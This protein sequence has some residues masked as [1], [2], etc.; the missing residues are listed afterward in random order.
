MTPEE[1]FLMTGSFSA[2]GSIP[3]SVV[4]CPHC[5]G[6]PPKH[7]TRCPLFQAT[8]IIPEATPEIPEV[9][10]RRLVI[11]PASDIR[12]RRVSWLW[13][14][15][16]KGAPPTSHGR[17]PMNALTIAAGHGGTG[18]TQ[19]ACWMTAQITRG[20]L[21]GELYGRP[22]SV[23][24]ASTE[25]SWSQT[26]APRLIAAGADMDRVFRIEVQDDGAM[27]ARLTLPI[28]TSLLGQAAEEHDA[29]LF[30]ADPLLSLLDDGINDYRAREVRSALEPLI[31][32][33]ERHRF[34][35]LG[36]AHFTKSGGADPLQR[37]AGSGAFGQMIRSLIAFS[38]VEKDDEDAEPEFVLSIEKNN[39]GRE[40]LPSFKYAIRSATVDTDEGPSLVS[41]FDLG[42]TSTTSVKEQMINGMQPEMDRGAVT[43]AAVWLE[44]WLADNHGRDAA[45]AIKKAAR[46]NGYAER[47]IDRA[48]KKLGLISAHSGF[49]KERKSE[50]VLPDWI[51]PEAAWASPRSTPDE[52][53]EPSEV[54]EVPEPD[55]LPG[56]DHDVV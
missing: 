6:T 14:T 15:T 46:A 11:T 48:K 23:F 40:G 31:S 25:D 56:I 29:V 47:T 10:P 26:L 44:G 3:Q 34:T 53:A 28:D 55:V 42:D 45:G 5:Y 18:K 2:N 41:R 8:I 37:L 16:P 50:W 1:E 33:A 22:H 27:S 35:I 30:V 54:D 13:D 38:E 51:D 4:T 36:I 43:D 19:F 24:Y 39:L 12:L 49:G 32:S 17:I 21:P 52:G 9:V 7:G 20:V